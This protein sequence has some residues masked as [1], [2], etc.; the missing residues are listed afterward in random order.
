MNC[1]KLKTAVGCA[2]LALGSQAA[3]ANFESGIP[4]G[5]TCTGNCGTL[6]A[7]GVVTAS[8]LATTAYGFVTTNKGVLGVSPFG[9]GGETDGSKLVSTSFHSNAGDAL[10]FFFNYVTSDGAGFA[11]YAWARLLNASD[12]SQAALLFDARTKPS[13]NIIP[14]QGMPVPDAAI[15]TATI[16]GGGPAWAPLGGSSGACFSAGC[17]FTGWVLSSFNIPTAGNYLLEFGVVNWADQI[18]DTGLAF[19]GLTIA[20]KPIGNPVP[21]PAALPLMLSGLGVFGL[22]RR[23]KDA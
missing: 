18:F 6:G 12:N 11:D 19:D 7:N 15:P 10:N 21:L 2:V 9:L 17:G 3:M 1:K 14:G 4:A 8:P 13:G 22:F 23:R 16:I 20:G 5:W